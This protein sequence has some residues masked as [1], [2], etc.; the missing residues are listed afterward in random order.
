VVD[1]LPIPLTI[2]HLEHSDDSRSLR[3]VVANPASTRFFGVE[4]EGVAGRLLADLIEIE[5][6][7]AD[8]LADAA[9][10]GRVLELPQIRSEQFGGVLSLRAVPLPERRLGLMLEDVTARARRSSSLEHQA[11]H[12]HLT[13]LPNRAMFNDRLATALER[14]GRDGGRTALLMVD[15]DQF[16]EVNDSL[17]HEVGD[18][19]LIE[20]AR[21]LSRE[22]R[23]FDTVARLGGDEFAVLLS[24]TAD[25]S[26]SQGAALRLLELCREP[27]EIDGLQL[28][29]GASI[30]IAL[31][32]LHAADARH[33]MRYADRAMYRAKENGG[34]IVVYAPDHDEDGLTRIDLL[35]DLRA[36]VST[37][38][39]IVHYQPRVDLGT[40]EVLGVEALV[41]W[42]H[43]RRGLLSPH[44][45]IELAEVSGEIDALTRTVTSRATAELATTGAALQLNVNLS[46]RCLAIGT[47][48]RWV[49]GLVD[50]RGI[51][52]TSLCFELGEQDLAEDPEL[53]LEGLHRLAEIGVRL[54]VDDFGTGGSSVAFLRQMPVDQL[55]I[56]RRLVAGILEDPTVVKS[57]VDL[58]HNLGLHVVAVGVE[59]AAAL[60]LLRAMGCDSAQGYHLA[61]PMRLDQLVR[62]LGADPARVARAPAVEVIRRS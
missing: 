47:L 3:V 38:D 34:G 6:D 26:S 60:E 55:K 43:P 48:H 11:T 59:S 40:D 57:M 44:E 56:D 20:L 30:G 10:H 62:H 29:V 49:R 32:P 39:V 15:L 24:D 8:A 61:P 50:R 7:L 21:R 23:H 4:P 41:R 18:R 35:T 54:S 16:K 1:G 58:G 36:A 46:A 28:Q 31:A 52:P 19:L 37:D 45:F 5:D 9:R 27:F 53:S 33:L 22:L 51:D 14:S 13:G 42:A 12:D 25:Q 17:G 2:L